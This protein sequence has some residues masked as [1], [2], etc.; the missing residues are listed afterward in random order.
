MHL[1]SDIP[2]K[3]LFWLTKLCFIYLSCFVGSLL[4]PAEHAHYCASLRGVVTDPQGTLVSDPTVTLINT[5]T[6]EQQV[7]ASSGNGIYKFNALPPA[8]SFTAVEKA[9]FKKLVISDYKVIPDRPNA[10]NV[11]F[12]VGD[13]TETTT[14][15]GTLAPALD[16]ETPFL[17]ETIGSNQ[18]QH[19]PDADLT[20]KDHASIAIYWVRVTNT[21]CNAPPRSANFWRHSQVNDAFLVICNHTF[22][23]TLLNEARA[24]SAGWLWDEVDTNP[25]APFGR[26]QNNLGNLGSANPNFF[27]PPGPSNLNQWTYDYNDILTKILGHHSINTGDDLTRLYYFNNSVYAARPLLGFRN[28]VLPNL[29]INAG[30]GWSYFAAFHAKQNNLDELQGLQTLTDLNIRMGGKL[31]TLQKNNFGPQ[32]GF[33]W[34][35][36]ESMNTLVVRH[37]FGINYNQQPILNVDGPPWGACPYAKSRRSNNAVSAQIEIASTVNGNEKPPNAAQASFCCLTPTNNYPELFYETA[38]PIHSIF[39]CA[40]NPAIITKF[41]I[42]NP[43]TI[44]QAIFV[45]GFPSNP[46]TIANYYYSL[47]TQYQLPYDIVATIGYQGRL[48][49]RLLMQSNYNMIAGVHGVALSP[50]ANFIDY[51]ADTGTG[52]YDALIVTLKHSFARHFN[53][54]VQYAWAKAMDEKPGPFQLFR[55]WQPLI[56]NGAQWLGGERGRRLVAHWHLLHWLSIIQPDL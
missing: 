35:P 2:K 37:A 38:T 36:R 48:A 5:K 17:G 6:N 47:D 1:T 25:K 22:S 18:I 15:N 32:L 30:L 44:G 10:L 11:Q 52:N 50:Y 34:Q 49:R 7:S 43:P 3:A 54:E 56:V 41:G 21:S 16:T 40:P 14:V 4:V 24:N 8:H 33:A 31:Y 29:T 46:T 51:Y 13:P 28:K 23:P 27:E 26:P 55:R 53:L 12:Q 42:K 9:G 45:T 20:Q 19:V 39:G